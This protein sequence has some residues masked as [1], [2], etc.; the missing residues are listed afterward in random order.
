M[1][2][3][4]HTSD[5]ACLFVFRMATG[6]LPHL[7]DPSVLNSKHAGP[8]TT[9]ENMCHCFDLTLTTY[10]SLIPVILKSSSTVYY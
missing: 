9:A 5:S 2:C 4:F 3:H 1:T 6:I 8:Y 7:S 10:F